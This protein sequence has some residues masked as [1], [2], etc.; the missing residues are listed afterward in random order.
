MWRAST[1]GFVVSY[2]WSP[3]D[4][5][6]RNPVLGQNKMIWWRYF[7][8]KLWGEIW[9]THLHKYTNTHAQIHCSPVDV[10]PRTQCLVK[11]KWYDDDGEAFAKEKYKIPKYTNIHCS[12]WF[13]R[14]WSKHNDMMVTG[15]RRRFKTKFISYIKQISRMVM[16]LDL[17]ITY[18]ASKEF[19]CHVRSW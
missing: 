15:S 14:H 1:C 7:S 5:I 13:H 6:P 12:L 2:H 16:T 11:T 3:A 8:S 17:L 19:P 9:N 10:I 4:V 18:L